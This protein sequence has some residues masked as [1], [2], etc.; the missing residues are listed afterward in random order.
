MVNSQFITD[1]EFTNWINIS[2]YELFDELITHYG[3][4]YFLADPFVIITDGV[5]QFYALPNDF[6]KLVGVDLSVNAS[7]GQWINV[8]KFNFADRNRYTQVAVTGPTYRQVM[9]YRLAGST[10]WL[11]PLPQAGQTLQIWYIPRDTNMVADTD[12]FD[13]I[14][15]WEEYVIVDV[16]IKALQKEESDVSALMAQKQAI[17]T[18][19]AQVAGN[20]DA[21]NPST[22]VDSQRANGGEFLPGLGYWGSGEM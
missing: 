2:S 11:N 5:N 7:Q 3:D 14:S 6:Y 13:G 9:T 8:P 20:R 12:V 16:S 18:R 22:V 17:L 15:G 19:I 21:A 1:A 4:D 10:L